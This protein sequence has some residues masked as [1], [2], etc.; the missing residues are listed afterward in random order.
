MFCFCF[1]NFLSL[2][3]V[4][5]VGRRETIVTRT[6]CVDGCFVKFGGFEQPLPLGDVLLS[7]S[8]A[9]SA[10]YIFTCSGGDGA[11]NNGS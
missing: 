11:E 7:R 2:L 8:I 3:V 9:Y 10:D 5:L 6:V 4:C 1:A